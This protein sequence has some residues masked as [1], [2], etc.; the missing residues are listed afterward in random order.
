MGINCSNDSKKMKSDDID[1]ID[2]SK[3]I[4]YDVYNDNQINEGAN[5]AALSQKYG[6]SKY[7]IQVDEEQNIR[8]KLDGQIMEIDQKTDLFQSPENMANL[9]QEVGGYYLNKGK[10]NGLQHQQQNSSQAQILEFGEYHNDRKIGAWKS[11]YNNNQIAGGYYNE[12]GNKNGMWIDISEG[13][14]DLKQVV[15]SGEYK[16][17]KKVGT[18]NTLWREKGTQ[19]F[20]MIGGGEYDDN[21]EQDSIKIGMWN[22]LD[23]QFKLGFQVIF[24]GEYHNGQKVGRWDILWRDE[25]RQPFQQIGGGQYNFND[26]K[27]SHKIGRW[28]ELSDAFKSDSQVTYN[29]PYKNGQKTGRWDIFWREETRSPFQLIG[30][31]QYED[32]EEKGS[33]KIGIWIEL[34]DRFKQDSQVTYKGQYRCGQKIGRWDICYKEQ[35]FGGGEYDVKNNGCSCKIG[36]W[37]DL[38]DE[39]REYSQVT[40]QGKYNQ[41]EKIG[42]WDIYYKF[43]NDGWKNEKIGGGSYENNENG[44]SLKTGKWVELSEGFRDFYQ[45]TYQGEYYKGKKIGIWLEKDLKKKNVK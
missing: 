45:I 20:S 27:G 42:Q 12:D 30:G 35:I 41:G 29:G 16:N 39:F 10:K 14:Y 17:G 40:Y 24:T 38:S 25:G 7:Q 18:W 19:N 34:R 6:N 9:E 36:N 26:E 3:A 13:F 1:Q 4:N 31:G 23:D 28:I 11:I 44:C 43:Y 2:Q 15:Y 32:D 33:R 8:C 5:Q 22:E 21:E 37:I